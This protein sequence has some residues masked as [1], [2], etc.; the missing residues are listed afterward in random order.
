MSHTTSRVLQAAVKA[1][2]ADARA[3]VLAEVAP[4]A[5]PLAKSSYG[6]F[7]LTKLIS[8]APKEE[9]PGESKEGGGGALWVRRVPLS[10]PASLM[11]HTKVLRYLSNGGTAPRRRRLRK[12][13]KVL[14]RRRPSSPAARRAPAVK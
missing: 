5:L 13:T 8:L 9:V 4:D 2:G 10:L 1:A 11:A 12:P 14:R 3:A 7:L 6:H